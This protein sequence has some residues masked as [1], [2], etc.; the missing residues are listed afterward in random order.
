MPGVSRRVLL[1]AIAILVVAGCGDRGDAQLTLRRSDDAVTPPTL[2]S[3]VSVESPANETPA[4][5]PTAPP[6]TAA[7]PTITTPPVT[8]PPATTE[9]VTTT[10]PFIPRV[11]VET[12]FGPYASAGGVVLHHPGAVV[13]RIGFH[14]SGHDGARQQDAL[15]GAARPFV[16]ETP[17]SGHR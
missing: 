6:T 12:G 7:L 13:E 9:P 3:P 8:T 14:E 17:R 1:V 5:D 15:A 16:M 2:V 4:T 10:R 11:T